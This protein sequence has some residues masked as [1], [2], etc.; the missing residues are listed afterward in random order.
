ML[1]LLIAQ[2]VYICLSIQGIIEK[3]SKTE[4]KVKE[5]G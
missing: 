1:I 4:E 5:K 3:Q 2:T